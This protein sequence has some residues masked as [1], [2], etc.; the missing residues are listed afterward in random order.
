[1]KSRLW[2]VIGLLALGSSPIQNTVV[3]ILCFQGYCSETGFVVSVKCRGANAS[4]SRL[5]IT[6]SDMRSVFLLSFTLAGAGLTGPDW[7]NIAV[8]EESR[9]ATVWVIV[10]GFM[11]QGASEIAT[12]LLIRIDQLCER[13][14]K[15]SIPR[16]CGPL[17][18]ACNSQPVK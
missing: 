5:T 2:L 9:A 3:T 13:A 8:T 14:R 17:H 11:G 18:I 16:E 6:S 10:P 4:E 15:R 7:A 1:M 12:V